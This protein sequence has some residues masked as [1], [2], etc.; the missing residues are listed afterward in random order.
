M[1]AHSFDPAALI[2]EDVLFET[3]H[4]P[5]F[6]EALA[7]LRA[8]IGPDAST[9]TVKDDHGGP[10][11]EIDNVIVVV[12]YDSQ[13][14]PVHARSGLMRQDGNTHL[15]SWITVGRLGPEWSDYQHKN[16]L[17][18]GTDGAVHISTM[19]TGTPLFFKERDR[20]FDTVVRQQ[21]GVYTNLSNGRYEAH[22]WMPVSEVSQL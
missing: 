13:G 17:Y 2:R 18:V 22:V 8:A 9:I 1:A 21:R 14:T 16:P 15:P 20:N 5:W 3:R 12:Q 10:D 11:F 7:Q 19:S 6:I 4:Q